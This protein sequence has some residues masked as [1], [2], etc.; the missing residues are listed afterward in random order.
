MKHFRVRV[1]F[2]TDKNLNNEDNNVRSQ[3]GFKLGDGS[4]R[5]L[6]P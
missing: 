2:S 6:Y 3:N 1:F 4:I 5:L